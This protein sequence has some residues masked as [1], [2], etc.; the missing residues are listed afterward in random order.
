MK[1]VERPAKFVD[2]FQFRTFLKE[3]RIEIVNIQDGLSEQPVQI[4]VGEIRDAV[5]IREI[6]FGDDRRGQEEGLVRMATSTE[7]LA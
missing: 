1:R 2:G 7:V 5:L 6:P 4:V 3:L